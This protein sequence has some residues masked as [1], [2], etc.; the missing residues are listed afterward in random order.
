MKTL[1]IFDIDNT[2][3][4]SNRIDSECFAKTY[5]KI[6]KRAFPTIDWR[7]YPHVTDT[8]I[9]STVIQRHFNRAV[10]KEEVHFF[11]KE[12]V[13]LIEKKRQLHPEQFLEVPNATWLIKG[14]IKDERFELGI[15]TG[16][17]RLPALVKL[18][19][20]GI[21][22]EA[23]IIS[24]ADGKWTREAI[25]QEVLDEVE[26]R[27]RII[28]KTVYIGDAIWDVTTTRNMNM[29]FIGIRR[30]GDFDVLLK[31]G[32]TQVLPDYSNEVAFFEA[33]EKAVPPQLF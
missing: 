12:F 14:L 7:Q 30:K 10:E 24:T 15:A 21:P 11:Q 16:G 23:F 22:K 3:L 8:T 18:G 2:L 19:H 6:Y 1:L 33:V 4:Y 20:I 28:E 25:I 26:K 32:A 17:W 29:N 13:A 5:E 27:Q 9:F 31:A